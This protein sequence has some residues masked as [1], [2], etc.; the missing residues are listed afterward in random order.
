MPQVLF[1]TK[2]ILSVYKRVLVVQNYTFI[3]QSHTYL[4]QLIINMRISLV[5]VV[6]VLLGVFAT[7][8][9]QSKCF[10]KLKLNF[11]YKSYCFYKQGYKKSVNILCPR[12]CF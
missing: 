7:A 3:G 4:Q 10:I 12:T 2:N 11:V 1:A 9:R 6:I 8:K 5:F